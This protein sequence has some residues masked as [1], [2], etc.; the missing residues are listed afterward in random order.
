M[1]R[2]VL[3][4]LVLA[5]A[6]PAFAQPPGLQQQTAQAERRERIKRRIQQVRNNELIDK[7]G[8]DEQTAGKLLLVYARYDDAFDRL[9]VA[10]AEILGRLKNGDRMAKPDLDKAIDDAVANQNALWEVETKRL[11]EV[12]KILTPQQ[13]ARMLVVMPA[14]ERKIQNQ[15]MRAIQGGPGGRGKGGMAKAHRPPPQQADDDDDDLDAP[16]E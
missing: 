3:V 2:A 4:V 12:R 5:I 10:R 9:L 7:L 6:A 14:L 11:G 1:R 16:R 13:V 8:L 15:L